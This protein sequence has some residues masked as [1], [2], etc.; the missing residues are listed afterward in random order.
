MSLS[1]KARGE[2]HM[3]RHVTLLAT[4]VLAFALA[5]CDGRQEQTSQSKAENQSHQS[6][7]VD[8]NSAIRIA[9]EALTNEKRSADKYNFKAVEQI[10]AWRI[11]CNLKDRETMGGGVIYFIDKQS[12]KI[13]RREFSQ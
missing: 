9:T 6:A 8:E 1:E 7:R 3:K 11:E 12:G 13:L 4:F 10:D 5:N 2:I